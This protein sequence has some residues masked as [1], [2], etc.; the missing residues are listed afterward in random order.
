MQETPPGYEWAGLQPKVCD[1]IAVEVVF[2]G[3]AA[4]RVP[5]KDRTEAA[6]MEFILSEWMK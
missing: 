1:G 5:K 4:A 3:Q 6:L 2:M